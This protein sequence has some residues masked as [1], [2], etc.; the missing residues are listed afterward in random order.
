VDRRTVEVYEARSEEW[1]DKRPAD[2]LD[3]AAALAARVRPGGLRVDLGCGPGGHCEALGAPVVALDAAS[4]MLEQVAASAP[5]ALRIRAD[6]EAL[7][8]RDGSLAAAWASKSYV[9]VPRAQVPLALADLH[10]SL[11]SEAPFELRLFLGDSEGELPNDPF[12]GRF[13]SLWD[14]DLLRDVV[15]GAGFEIEAEVRLPSRRGG[16]SLVLRGRRSHTLADTV[17]ADMRLLVVGLNPSLYAAERGVAFARPGNRFWPAAAAAGLVTRDR[18]PRHALL[19]H[20]LGMSDLVKRATRRASELRAEE[21]RGGLARIERI[22]AWL[23]P[24]ALCFVGLAGYRHAVERRARPGWQAIEIAGA[25]VYLMPSTSGLNAHSR[26]EDLCRHLRC[27][28]GDPPEP[29]ARRERA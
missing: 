22:A 13:F 29:R 2:R 7:P 17:G 28:A 6:V 11:E 4:A 16:D 19:G 3:A 27:A 8:F 1:R 25:P 5:H 21:Y 23:R 9:H 18:D 14:R 15:R 12:A 20:G 24:R 10:R 26:L